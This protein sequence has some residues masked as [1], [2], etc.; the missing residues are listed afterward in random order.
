MGTMLFP[1][2][3]AYD[4]R[5]VARL[6]E[7]ARGCGANGFVTTE[8]DAVKLTPVL[9][10]RLESIGPIVIARL[11]VELVEEKDALMQLV[12]MVAGLDRR[13]RGGAA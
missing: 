9:R 3:H 6:M 11:N 10:D 7:R 5:D 2:H 8:K 4:E 12:S 13:R 1:D